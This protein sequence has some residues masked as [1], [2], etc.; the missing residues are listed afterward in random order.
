MC[1]NR[2]LSL[3]DKEHTELKDQLVGKKKSANR[4]ASRDDLITMVQCGEM[5]PAD[6]E[7]EAK[8]LRLGPLASE[9]DPN[10]YDP[11]RS[12][13]AWSQQGLQVGR[14]IQVS[15]GLSV[16]DVHS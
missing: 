4:E 10:D 12:V 5:A 2:T 15:V 16:Q 7:S 1:A 13:R 6:A 11:T 9:P 14:R 3:W 8:R